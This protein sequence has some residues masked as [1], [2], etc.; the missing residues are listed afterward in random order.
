MQRAVTAGWTHKTDTHIDAEHH[1]TFSARCGDKVIKVKRINPP[2]K[3]FSRKRFH[4]MGFV[5]VPDFLLTVRHIFF[6]SA[7]HKGS[8]LMIW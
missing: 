7:G 6:I 3:N 4:Y 1:N 2:Y 8:G 5:L